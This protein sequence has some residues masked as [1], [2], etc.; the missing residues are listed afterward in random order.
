MEKPIRIEGND[1]K[2]I[3]RA[4]NLGAM[5]M[6]NAEDGYFIPIDLDGE[7]VLGERLDEGITAF[8][9]GQDALLR[10]TYIE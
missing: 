10:A 9:A 5:L 4:L 6:Q 8:K 7:Q 2:L 3:T 1:F